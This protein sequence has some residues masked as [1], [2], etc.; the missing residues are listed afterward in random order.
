M[1]VIQ[2]HV[3]R[4][5]LLARAG[6]CSMMDFLMYDGRISP[7]EVTLQGDRLICRR[8]VSESGQFRLSW[9]RFNGS[10]QVVH[11]TSLREQ[12]DPYEL[13]LELA[14]GQLS[15]LRNQFSIWH[16]SGLQSS[17]KLDELIRESHRSFR[18]AALR[19]EVPE[20]SAAAA[21]LSM[22]LSAQAA[23]MLCEHYVA[24]RIEFRRQRATRI[25]VL[26]GCHLN[27]IPQQESEFLRTFN[28]IQVAV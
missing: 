21:V 20:T 12:P 7:A 13:E 25:P 4:P 17:A 8:S 2:F 28:A 18:A 3:Q 9:P 11:S 6:G 26:L 5:D 24:Q 10:S 27:Q 14:R 1:G 19:A 23:D 16:G 22:E 15:R